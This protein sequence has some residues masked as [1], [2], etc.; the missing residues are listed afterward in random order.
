MKNI[1]SMAVAMKNSM[2]VAMKKSG[3][4]PEVSD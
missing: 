1:Y 4:M 2:A 3:Y